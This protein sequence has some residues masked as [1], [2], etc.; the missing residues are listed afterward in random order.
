MIILLPIKGHK[1]QSF[2]TDRKLCV[3]D[4]P[5][6]EHKIVFFVSSV[7]DIFMTAFFLYLYGKPMN[8]IVRHEKHNKSDNTN[9]VKLRRCIM[10]NFVCSATSTIHT[11]II[12]L[13]WWNISF[14]SWWI[15]MDYVVNCLCLFAMFASNRRCC[16]H[17]ICCHHSCSEKRATR[18]YSINLQ[19][20]NDAKPNSLD[21]PQKMVNHKK[22]S[23]TVSDFPKPPTILNDDESQPA[24]KSKY[25]HIMFPKCFNVDIYII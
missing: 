25:V 8:D 13:T 6:I 2:N 20:Q 1:K 7:A 5:D 10:V 22:L 12:A 9:E 11:A 16:K 23:C 4:Q 24:A 18:N 15:V 17:S 14:M 3:W 21:L 19:T